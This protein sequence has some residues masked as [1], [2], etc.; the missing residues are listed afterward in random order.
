MKK[1]ILIAIVVLGLLAFGA[2][3]YVF[4][5]PHRDPGAEEA[6]FQMSA[7]EL[8]EEFEADQQAANEKYI[9]QVVAIHGVAMEVTEEFIIMDNVINCGLK[10]G[11]K[12]QV[13]AG[14]EVTIKGRVIGY[15]DLFGEVKMDNCVL[16]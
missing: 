9:D 6:V 16:P 2:Y 5:K 7:T 12:I 15:D 13:Q 11:N 4:N 8:A 10:P 14:D 3:W 1:I